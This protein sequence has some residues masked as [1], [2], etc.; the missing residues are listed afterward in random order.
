MQ[1]LNRWL[2]QPA[3]NSG[4]IRAATELRQTTAELNTEIEACESLYAAGRS[5]AGRTAQL[6]TRRLRLGESMTAQQSGWAE[7]EA[8]LSGAGLAEKVER[9]R[10]FRQEVEAK[11]RRLDSDLAALEAAAAAGDASEVA[12]RLELI[13]TVLPRTTAARMS[14]VAGEAAVQAAR[15]ERLTAAPGRNAE[16]APEDLAESKVIRF[17]PEIRARVAAMGNDPARIIDWVWR[18]YDFEPYYGLVLGSAGVYWA[19]RGSSYDLSVFLAACLRAAGVPARLVAV[20]A[21]ASPADLMNWLGIKDAALIP[22]LLGRAT[23][24]E[25]AGDYINF[26]QVVVEA[27]LPGDSGMAW[28]GIDVAFKVR[29]AREGMKLDPPEFNRMA[30]LASTPVSKLPS[31]AYLDLIRAQIAKNYPLKS[32]SDAG[33]APA[34]AGDGALPYKVVQTY[35]RLSEIWPEFHQKA[36]VE[37]LASGTET[38]YA[39][40]IISLPESIT[41]SISLTFGPAAAADQHVIALF[42]GLAGAPAAAVS[43]VPKLRVGAAVVASGTTALTP[44]EYV[45]LRVAQYPAR[46]TTASRVVTHSVIAG[47]V[48]VVG[49]NQYQA[50]PGFVTARIDSLLEQSPALGTGLQDETM[51]AILQIAALRYFDR[52]DTERRRLGEPMHLRFLGG[53][54]AEEA[55]TRSTLVVGNAFDRPFVVTPSRTVLDAGGL[56]YGF[57]NVDSADTPASTYSAFRQMLGLT[58]SSLEHEL[59]EE[60]TLVPSIS[61]TKGLELALASKAVV[62]T[63][64]RDNA[65]TEI[66]TLEVAASLKTRFQA[67]VDAG[68]TVITTSGPI[69]Y[70]QWRGVPWISELPGSVAAHY[71]S[72][73]MGGESTQATPWLVGAPVGSGTSGDGWQQSNCGSP[74]CVSN[75]NMFHQFSDFVLT[76]RG[77]PIQLARTYNSRSSGSGS[78]GYGWTHNYLASL[79][80]NQGSMDYTDAS[81]AVYRFTAKSGGYSAPANLPLQLSK[82]AQGFLL[83]SKTGMQARFD[84]AGKLQSLTDRNGN[85]H[86]LTYDGKGNL[87]SVRD[88]DGVGV[89]LG[90]DASN[91]VTE[92]TDQAGR[93]VSFVYDQRGDLVSST[94]PGG[95]QTSF[96]YYA[97]RFDDH[98]LRTIVFPDQATILFEYYGNDKVSR[99][100]NPAGGSMSFSYRPLRNETVVTDERGSAT[101]FQYNDLGYVTRI[102][103]PDGNVVE[104]NWSAEGRLLS[105]TDEAGATNQ[106]SYDAN[107]NLATAT[108]AAGNRVEFAYEPG[109][110]Q[111]TRLRDRRGNVTRFEY[112]SRGN[113]TKRI[114]P[115]GNVWSY[116]WD[117]AGNLLSITDP[118]GRSVTL[119]YDAQGNLVEQRNAAGVVASSRFDSLRRITALVDAVG[120]ETQFE[121]DAAGYN[122]KVTNALG[123]TAFYE[124]DGNGRVTRMVDFAGR[125]SSSTYDLMGNPATVTDASGGLTSY[126]YTPMDGSLPSGADLLGVTTAEGKTWLNEYDFAG[127][128]QSVIDPLGHSGSYQYDGRGRLAV[129][130]DRNGAERRLERDALNQVTRIVF[131]DGTEESYTY[132]EN[133]NMTHAA[134]SGVDYW[135]SYDAMNRPAQMTDSRTGATITHAYDK[136]GRLAAITDA[137]GGVTRYERDANGAITSITG[138]GGA[139]TRLAYDARGLRTRLDLPNGVKATYDY[140]ALGRLTSLVYSNDRGE[141][142]LLWN[143]GY[144]Q[145]GNRVS[146]VDSAGPHTYTYDEQ[147]RLTG[148]IHPDQESESYSYDLA[149]NRLGSGAKAYTHDDEGQLTSDSEA[150][151]GYDRQGNVVSRED[152]KGKVKYVYNASNR[153]VMVEMPGGP[154]VKFTYDAMGRRIAKSVDGATTQYFWDGDRLIAETGPEGSQ[155]HYLNGIGIDEILG[156]RSGER[157]YYVLHDGLGSAAALTDET[158]AVVN[159]YRYDSFGQMQAEGSVPNRLTYTGREYDAE[160]GLYYFRARYYDARTGRFLQQ[161]P[162][163]HS[164]LQVLALEGAGDIARMM[165]RDGMQR[166][167]AMNPYAYAGQNPVARTDPFGLWPFAEGPS[168]SVC[169]DPEPVPPADEEKLFK[170]IEGHGQGTPVLDET[171]L[172]KAFQRT[173]WEHFHL[174]TFYTIWDGLEE[175]GYDSKTARLI[176]D[177]EPRTLLEWFLH[178][179]HLHRPYSIYKTN[180]GY[181]RVTWEMIKTVSNRS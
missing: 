16:P 15:V 135:I 33:Y 78:L 177:I 151:F 14:G 12:A 4:L 114:D 5:L 122:R 1:A 126:R 53:L 141:T 165:L 138:P 120:G 29:Q 83:R 43:L 94:A 62:K 110:T 81:G 69:N 55:M 51:T 87:L 133:G 128:V 70:N 35:W 162:L 84:A 136:S 25:Q 123:E 93:R 68:R 105:V 112:D 52:F 91:R 8:R 50:T 27:W 134:G 66:A 140:D 58:S 36:V 142:L 80:D 45:R 19:G 161:D 171:D 99:I 54:V 147:D 173:P 3:T 108:D 166:T 116:G 82:D 96:S 176:V 121:Y 158:G 172:P 125:A 178:R 157:T 56:A 7:V 89:V 113:R 168:I 169:L 31:E 24:V 41:D 72:T 79:K 98:N 30:F 86:R 103:R 90:Y 42:G 21:Q 26:D 154:E 101:T 88:G 47:E 9:W 63:I 64:T 159:R 95:A 156:I 181:V 145:A 100:V 59:W 180:K 10:A 40:A 38:S 148:A 48:A 179:D 153:L 127:R 132:D 163:N 17:T 39:K 2:N 106:Y 175:S 155:T 61:T 44:G 111:L 139:I 97:D 124:Y 49:L 146:I 18:N 149:G 167:M 85:Q 34:I 57:L 75:G 6:R 115:A 152:S 150:V 137:E 131:S 102:V 164:S 20:Q 76:A 144:D 37:V 143:Y 28:R 65:A 73:Y 13:R 77:F 46:M 23:Y 92:V 11:A 174:S 67:E 71:V 109:F 117:S 119:G 104:Q 118:E 22:V 74:V 160:T 170:L 129:V 130:R 60:I 107:G 32:I